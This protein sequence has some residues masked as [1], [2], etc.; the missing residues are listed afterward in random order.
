MSKKTL[1]DLQE[2]AK[3]RMDNGWSDLTVDELIAF[4]P[5]VAL[6]IP[7]RPKNGR[8]GMVYIREL[9]AKEVLRVVSSKGES[10]DNE[11]L[12]ELMSLAVVDRS[13]EMLF[14]SANVKRLS[15]SAFSVFT[16]IQAK[17][18]E[19]NPINSGGENP[20]ETTPSVESPTN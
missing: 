4:N 16:R 12:F 5:I 10:N 6:E 20:L 7:E 13:G 9:P 8:P 3:E 14:T 19:L 1:S 17:V 15:D 18:L 2:E 11:W